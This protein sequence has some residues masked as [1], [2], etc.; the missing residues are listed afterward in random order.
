M[1]IQAT[2]IA[3][4][5]VMS[6]G[7]AMQS[8]QVSQRSMVRPP[9]DWWDQDEYERLSLGYNIPVPDPAQWM[10]VGS[11]DQER[12]WQPRIGGLAYLSVRLVRSSRG[13]TLESTSQYFKD[14]MLSEFSGAKLKKEVKSRIGTADAIDVHAEV[15][16]TF[17]DTIKIRETYA[18]RGDYTIIMRQAGLHWYYLMSHQTFEGIRVGFRLP[19]KQRRNSSP[20]PLLALR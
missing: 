12:K 1:R 5:L 14:K 7:C 2:V 13:Q 8:K 18:M 19:P 9:A 10:V 16:T 17:G 3:L 20:N 6:A 15:Q 4:T 11:E